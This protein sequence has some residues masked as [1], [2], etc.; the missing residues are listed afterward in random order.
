[1]SMTLLEFP[2]IKSCSSQTLH[3]EFFIMF[4]NLPF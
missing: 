4:E 3:T 1:M 2:N